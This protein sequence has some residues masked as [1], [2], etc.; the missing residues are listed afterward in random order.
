MEVIT[1]H[2]ISGQVAR[3]IAKYAGARDLDTKIATLRVWAIYADGAS[4]KQE[5]E[6]DFRQV[7]LDLQG[8]PTL[9]TVVKVVKAYE[10]EIIARAVNQAIGTTLTY[11]DIT[12]EF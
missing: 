3:I 4:K 6:V 2:P 7:V 11:D 5:V 8:T 10:K 12:L 1:D 9:D